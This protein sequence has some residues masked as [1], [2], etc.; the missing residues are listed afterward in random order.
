MI[1]DNN[2]YIFNY[3]NNCACNEDLIFNLSF[4]L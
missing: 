3:G 1:Y 2:K 4:M